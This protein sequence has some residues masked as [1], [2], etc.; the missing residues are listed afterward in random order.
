[1]TI[2]K[3]RYQ[4]IIK[5]L[6]LGNPVAENDNILQEARVSTPAF[7]GVVND[8]YDIVT[9][10]KGA[11]KTAIFRII[12]DQLKPFYLVK[13]NTIILSGVNS[14]GESIFDQFRDEFSSFDENKFENFW[15]LYFISLIHNQFIKNPEYNENFS[16]CRKE[17]EVFMQECSKTGI[18]NIPAQQD[19]IEIIRWA[20]QFFGRVKKVRATGGMD[21]TNPNLL[22]FSTELELREENPLSKSGSRSTYIMWVL[23]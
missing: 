12:G 18:P 16:D 21:P 4:E 22:L 14:S 2:N 9:G 3:S 1:M 5:S 13:K 6:K 17:I 19:R 11:G 8:K 10:R 20:L 23:L 7:E 15:K